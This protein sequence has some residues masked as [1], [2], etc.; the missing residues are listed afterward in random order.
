MIRFG[1]LGPAA[2]WC[3]DRAVE[4]GSPQQRTLFA[5]LLLHRGE[6]VATDRMIDVLWPAGAPANALQERAIAGGRVLGEQR[7]GDIRVAEEL[8]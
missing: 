7:R 8:R 3:D 5:L 2:A 1:L 6:V 4:L